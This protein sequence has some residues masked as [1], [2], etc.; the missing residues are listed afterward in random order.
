A[1]R[2]ARQR[3]AAAHEVGMLP[4]GDE[5]DLLAVLLRRDP[6]PEAARFLA[7]GGL[8]EVPDRESRARELRLR[9]REEEVRLVLLRVHAA[10][11]AVALRRLVVVDLRV[12]PGG[13]RPGVETGG[14]LDQRPELQVAVAV[15]A[16]NG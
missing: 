13:D 8:V 3:G 16:R 1:D 4:G 5:A 11:Q 14:P 12:M 10:A 9:Q 2:A 6:Q 15:H 7:D